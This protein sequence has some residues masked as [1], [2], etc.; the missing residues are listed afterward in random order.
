MDHL[1]SPLF[2]PSFNGVYWEI[3]LFFNDYIFSIFPVISKEPLLMQR[4]ENRD[5]QMPTLEFIYC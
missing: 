4:N 1:N 5:E 3:K 2:P